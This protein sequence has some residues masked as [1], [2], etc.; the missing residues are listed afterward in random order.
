MKNLDRTLAALTV[1]CLTVSVILIWLAARPELTPQQ[2]IAHDGE[3]APHELYHDRG[4]SVFVRSGNLLAL[5][6]ARDRP[7]AFAISTKARLETPHV[8]TSL[9]YLIRARA[10]GGPD[11]E[12]FAECIED[13]QQR[14]PRSVPPEHSKWIPKVPAGLNPQGW[15]MYMAAGIAAQDDERA[16]TELQLE[17]QP[18]IIENLTHR[19]V[20][21]AAEDG[22][23]RLLLPLFGS[24][25]AGIGYETSLRAMLRG[26]NRAVDAGS[27]P[28]RIE[29][30]FYSSARKTARRDEFFSELG[31]LTTR[32]LRDA[33]VEGAWP[34]SATLRAWSQL[35]LLIACTLTAA[36]LAGVMLR[37]TE[38]IDVWSLPKNAIKWALIST[39]F[40]VLKGDPDLALAPLEPRSL[41]VLAVAALVVPLLEFHELAAKDRRKRGR[42]PVS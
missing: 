12:K 19:T 4:T 13:L 28:A 11:S 10:S 38:A 34:R 20:R 7:V 8:E 26:I 1:G 21:Q 35:A 39:G 9:D 37:S 31:L 2:P 27:A 3:L 22:V 32:I 17:L 5:E 36:A 24:G 14:A 16:P 29:L 15:P 41:L 40:L 42:Q 33:S 18:R 30:V 6:P 25:A 23:E